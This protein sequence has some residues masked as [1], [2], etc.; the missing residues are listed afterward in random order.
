[1]VREL[2]AA[3]HWYGT[4]TADYLAMQLRGCHGRVDLYP[5]AR[6]F[7]LVNANTNLTV[8]ERDDWKED[9]VTLFGVPNHLNWAVHAHVAHLHAYRPLAKYPPWVDVGEVAAWVPATDPDMIGQTVSAWA[10]G[11]EA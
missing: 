8:V 10:W 9:A 11:W 2:R 1:M 5:L 4:E 7:D 6:E 3:L